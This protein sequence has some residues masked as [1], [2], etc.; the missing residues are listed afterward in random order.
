MSSKRH[1][2][3]KRSERSSYDY[4]SSEGDGCDDNDF[5]DDAS[6][7]DDPSSKSKPPGPKH[8]AKAEF[9]K[10]RKI[11]IRN[12]PPVK[13]EVR[14]SAIHPKLCALPVYMAIVD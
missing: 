3:H 9:N 13:Y 7:G 14:V 2:K 1:R 11:I 12:V 5:S 10:N 4:S 8:F 6:A